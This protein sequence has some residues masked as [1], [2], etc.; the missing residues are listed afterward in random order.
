LKV[1]KGQVGFLTWPF[2]EAVAQSA[3]NP[4]ALTTGAQR[5]VSVL[6]NV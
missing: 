2:F 6:I 4:E 5:A 3:V 1:R